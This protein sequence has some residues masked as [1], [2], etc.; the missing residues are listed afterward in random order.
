MTAAPDLCPPKTLALQELSSAASL[1]KQPPALEGLKDLSKSISLLG[2]EEEGTPQ[3]Q[4]PQP[5]EP[6][7]RVPGAS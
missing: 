6:A 2:F 1:G 5:Q 4:Q 3:P 7:A